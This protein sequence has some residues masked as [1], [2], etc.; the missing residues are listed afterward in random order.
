MFWEREYETMPRE[1]LE[2]LQLERLQ[3]TIRRVYRSV[4][5]YRDLFRERGLEPGDIKS[6]DDLKKLPFTC[7][8]DLR[9]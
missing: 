5:F 6:L 8:Q 2:K 7:K 3:E 1:N 4:P 9:D